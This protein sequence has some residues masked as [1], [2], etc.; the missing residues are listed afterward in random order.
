MPT[1]DNYFDIMIY[2]AIFFQG[3]NNVTSASKTANTTDLYNNGHYRLVRI[4]LSNV[5]KETANTS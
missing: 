3:M 2:D 5:N 4:Y 1:G